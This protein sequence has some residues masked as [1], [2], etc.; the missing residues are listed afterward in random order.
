MSRAI[1][2]CEFV[3]ELYGLNI[4]I[5]AP[6]KKGTYVTRRAPSSLRALRRDFY[7]GLLYKHG[8]D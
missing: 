7:L 1:S 2:I 8:H 3:Q 4:K 5:S 6:I